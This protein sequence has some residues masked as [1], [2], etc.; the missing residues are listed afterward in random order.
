[1]F[2]GTSF[3]TGVISG[4]VS[5]LQDTRALTSGQMNRGEYAANTTKNVTGA[6][7]TMAGIEYGSILG[8]SIMPGVGTVAGAII[9]AMAG[10][11]LGR[12]VGWHTGNMLFSKEST[13]GINDGEESSQLENM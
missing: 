13:R 5:Q 12:Y 9:G 3:W 7:G 8:T 10:D 11:R 4:G 2:R 6:V 1:M